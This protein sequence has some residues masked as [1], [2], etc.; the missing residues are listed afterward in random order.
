MIIPEEEFI[1]AYIKLGSPSAVAKHF[2]MHIRSVHSRRRS[3]ENR[4]NISLDTHSDGR[5]RDSTGKIRAMA[6]INQHKGQINLEITNGI[7][8]VFSD[9]HY[10]PEI[11]TVAHRA[12][13]SICDQ[14]KPSIIINN[15]DA[16]D[17]AT[18]SRFPRPFYD[19]GK[20]NVLQELQAVDERL[21]EIEKT[22][23]GARKIWCLGN[24]DLRFEARLAANSPEYQ[25]VSGFHLKDRFPKWEPAWSCMIND[26]VEVRHRY[27]GG[28][29]AT[30]N[31][32]LWNHH[33]TITGHLHSM[34]ITPFTDG[35]GKVKYGVDTGTLADIN[36]PQFTD[37][38]EGRIANWRSGF[39]VLT[40]REGEMLMPELVQKW[41]EDHVE[42]RGHILN[43][44]T[45]KI[46]N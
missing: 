9:A 35:R 8:I 33:T 36:G 16:F 19:E 29:H 28:I 37:Y 43:A 14:L 21:G 7:V 12:L 30:H 4:L 5:I 44:D 27:K 40:F 25:G 46:I 17:G 13:V 11:K 41:D 22:I 34:K 42:F 20:P 10:W 6:M 1:A 26:S 18:L 23:N 24:H 32:V 2:C 38:M 31:N 3:I 15:G 45:L 39:V